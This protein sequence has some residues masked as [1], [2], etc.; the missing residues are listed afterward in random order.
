ML[1]SLDIVKFCCEN[2]RKLFY[3]DNDRPMTYPKLQKLDFDLIS[4]VKAKHML[5]LDESIVPSPALT[6]LN[7]PT[8]YTFADDT[9]FRGNSD[10]LEY[11][12]ITFDTNLMEIVKR[13]NV[14]SGGKY[15]KLSHI[16]ARKTSRINIEQMGFESF[17]SF[18]TSLISPETRSFKISD[19]NPQHPLTDA[20]TTNRVAENI[21]ILNLGEA[22]LVLLDMLD[23][24]K[25]LPNVTDFA[26]LPGG[27][28]LELSKKRGKLIQYLY[29]D[30]YPL[31]HCLRC[32]TLPH[33]NNITARSIALMSI[34]LAILC[35]KF[36]F[37]DLP[38]YENKVYNYELSM[39]LA[40]KGYK[41]YTA[42]I[43]PLFYYK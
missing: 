2:L 40:T 35:T 20:I 5:S 9:L 18:A 8:T 11:L 6:H 13:Y 25:L 28:G 31:S 36:T 43:K 38:H 24:I 30:Y 17:A 39:I 4:Y 10:T 22:K 3:D 19:Y 7:W 26:C 32:W 29:A 27:I 21:R 33:T 23:L 15:S 42:K 16:A 1:E 37:T 14:F 34:A 12:S 41:K